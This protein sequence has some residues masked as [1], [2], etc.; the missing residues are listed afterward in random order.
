MHYNAFIELAE[1]CRY[2]NVFQRERKKEKKE[3]RLKEEQEAQRAKQP[4]LD[5]LAKGEHRRLTKAGRIP[6]LRER[7]KMA[8]EARRR[9]K[10]LA[11]I[12][13]NGQADETGDRDPLPCA[14]ESLT[15]PEQEEPV[16]LLE[17]SSSPVDEASL[18]PEGLLLPV[19]EPLP[20][21]GD[22][23]PRSIQLETAL[24]KA[25]FPSTEQGQAKKGKAKRDAHK[26]GEASKRW[27]SGSGRVPGSST[28]T[29]GPPSTT[30]A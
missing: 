17:G 7:S 21:A 10:E 11:D 30:R 14:E 1:F 26:D 4:K 19:F 25:N 22:W 18:L 29:W 27:R 3:E 8:K 24:V 20:L 9:A 15:Q 12:E 5:Q 2:I 28:V 16:V 6:M 13:E 23:I